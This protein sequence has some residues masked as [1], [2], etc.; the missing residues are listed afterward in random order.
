MTFRSASRTGNGRNST[1]SAREKSVTL[2]PMPSASVTTA[3]AANGHAARRWRAASRQSWK[4]SSISVPALLVVRAY[5]SFE[6][7]EV[8]EQGFQFA[9][10]L[11][12]RHVGLGGAQTL[13]AC[14]HLSALAQPRREAGIRR[15]HTVLI[16]LQERRASQCTVATS[17]LVRPCLGFAA[18]TV[19]GVVEH[20][21]LGGEPALI[22]EPLLDPGA[23]RLKRLPDRDL[24][25][26]IQVGLLFSKCGDEELREHGLVLLRRGVRGGDHDAAAAGEGFEELEAA[27]A[28]IDEDHAAGQRLDESGPL[29]GG[30]IGADQVEPGTFVS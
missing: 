5:L 8:D 25:V 15:V 13:D 21:P 11:I 27:A 3:A 22:V 19:A 12:R 18:D 24:A 29:R 4:R 16:A 28:P 20:R 10:V 30:Q 1:E 6:T 26:A 7:G 9:F 23:R 17:C 2:A 14:L